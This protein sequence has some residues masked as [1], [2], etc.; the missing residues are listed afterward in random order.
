MTFVP[1]KFAIDVANAQRRLFGM[2]S[3]GT[4]NGGQE[5]SSVDSSIRK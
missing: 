4:G 1:H 2:T 5:D 3:C